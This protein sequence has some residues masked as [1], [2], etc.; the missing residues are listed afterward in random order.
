MKNAREE[1]D[2]KHVKKSRS[3]FLPVQKKS[4]ARIP[5]K[6]SNLILPMVKN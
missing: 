4:K 6:N 5:S 2:F 3:V 1:G